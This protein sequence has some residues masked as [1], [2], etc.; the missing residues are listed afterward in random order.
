MRHLWLPRPREGAA[1]AFA[2]TP[3][4]ARDT[5]WREAR[6]CAIDLELTGLDPRSNDIIAIGAVPIEDGRVLLGES[7]Y[8]LV[9][10]SRRSEHAAVLVHKLRLP[11]V[12]DAPVLAEAL[13]LLLS[14]LAGRVPV[15]HTAAVERSFLRPLFSRRRLR[16]PDAADTEVLGRVWLQARDSEAP[17]WLSLARVAELLRVPA[18]PPHHALGDALTTGKSFV[19][20]ASHLDALEPQTVGTLVGARSKLVGV[21]R[22]GPGV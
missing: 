14:V 16:L 6:W 11:D 3:A 10:S 4:A 18:E 13:E 1:A 2:R 12:A 17:S 21:R 9:R 8:T 7:A 22:F 19:A 15:F 20:L 5:P